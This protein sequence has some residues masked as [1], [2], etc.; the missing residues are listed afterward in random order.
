[1]TTPIVICDDSKLARKQLARSLPPHWDVSVSFAADG[2]EA[3]EAIKQGKGEILF[4]DLN[5]P[6]MDGYEVLQA[7]RSHDLATRVIVVSGDVQPEAY[8]R[9]KQLGALEFIKK[10]VQSQQIESL[11]TDFG[12]TFE[13]DRQLQLDDVLVDILDGYREIVNIAIGRAGDLLARLLDAFIILPIPNINTMEKSDLEMTLQ[14]IEK[15]ESV[16]A[17]C[18]GLIGAGI[19]GE[20]MLIFNE[21]SF[22]DIAELM[23]F[24]GEID[25]AAKLELLMDLSCILIGASL[26]GIADQ[27][28]ISFSQSHPCILGTHIRISDILTQLS[29]NWNKILA[30]EIPYRIEHRE[31]NCEL[32][33]LFTED[34]IDELNKRISY[35]SE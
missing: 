7:I 20:A 34:S 9:V 25:D 13:S 35:L 5:M 31:I 19:A 21:S 1:M 23:K 29:K 15:R 17:V 32:L 22:S 10:P 16:S 27:L 3:I 11:L 2:R 12:I 30:I 4:L 28:D 6:V 24:R 14:Q 18:Q 33:L 26:K 8:R